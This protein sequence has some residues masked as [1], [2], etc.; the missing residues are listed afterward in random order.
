[1][2]VIAFLFFFI[3]CEQN[4]QQL[5][6]SQEAQAVCPTPVENNDGPDIG[7]EVEEIGADLF[8]ARID[9]NSFEKTDE[10]KVMAAIEIIK[11]V[12]KSKIFKERVLSFSFNGK[13]QFND[14]KGLSNFEIYEL[15][16]SGAEELLPE[17]DHEMDLELELYYSWKNTIGYTTPGEMKIYLNRKFFNS[18]TPVQVAGNLFH[19]WTHKLGFNHA[20]TYTVDRDSSVPYALGYLI[21]ELGAY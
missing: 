9:F 19:E 17:V 21:E 7:A 1:M 18:F 16:L 13:R 4:C 5:G 10:E 2:L 3:S 11:K 6:S 12:I 15:L 8:S 20:S 14:N